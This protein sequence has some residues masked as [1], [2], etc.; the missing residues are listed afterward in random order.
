[1]SRGG[2]RPL[3]AASSVTTAGGQTASHQRDPSWSLSTGNLASSGCHGAAAREEGKP[4]HPA[5]KTKTKER[6]HVCACMCMYVRTCVRIYVHMCA[7][8]CM[9]V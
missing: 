2:R 1:M 6:V 8:M 9:Y 4:A 5:K 3:G 7:C